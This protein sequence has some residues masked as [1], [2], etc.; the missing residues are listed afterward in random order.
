MQDLDAREGRGEVLAE[1]QGIGRHLL[2]ELLHDRLQ[3]EHQ[4]LVVH[5]QGFIGAQR[6]PVLAG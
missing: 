6:D 1:A 2:P 4:V 3:R 5:L